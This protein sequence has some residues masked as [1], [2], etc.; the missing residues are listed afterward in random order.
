MTGRRAKSHNGEMTDFSSRR[1]THG[2]LAQHRACRRVTVTRTSGAPK[3]RPRGRSAS[4]LRRPTRMK[5]S[6]PLQSSSAPE[7]LPAFVSRASFSN[8]AADRPDRVSVSRV[9]SCSFVVLVGRGGGWKWKRRVGRTGAWRVWFVV[10][11][12]VVALGHGGLLASAGAP[13]D[14]AVSR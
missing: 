11:C 3:P 8:P 5:S 14:P 10:F 13:A 2:T 4:V 6:L 1:R 9:H 7:N 12:T